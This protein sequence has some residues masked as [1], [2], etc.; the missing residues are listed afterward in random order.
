[1]KLP[2]GYGSI[3]KV[4]GEKRRNPYRVRI[5]I[6]KENDPVTGKCKRKY[7]TVG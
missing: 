3:S 7:K 2:N 6:G 4:N 5:L 1:M